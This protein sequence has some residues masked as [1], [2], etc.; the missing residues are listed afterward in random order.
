MFRCLKIHHRSYTGSC[1]Q[2]CYMMRCY[3][4]CDCLSYTR[5]CLPDSIRSKKRVKV[6]AQRVMSAQSAVQTDKKN[7]DRLLAHQRNVQK[8]I[9]V[10][11]PFP[12][13]P[14]SPLPRSPAPPPPLSLS[15]SFSLSL[16]LSLSLPLA[17]SLSHTQWHSIF[18]TAAV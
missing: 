10:H 11:P 8:G 18:L 1:H 6:L 9:T 12:P 7:Y 14:L 17:P 16:S 15:L 2:Y 3:G 5:W 13:P 4:K